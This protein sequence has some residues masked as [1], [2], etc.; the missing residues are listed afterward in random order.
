MRHAIDPARIVIARV[1][2][3][4]K[5]PAPAPAPTPAPTPAIAP[6]GIT[7]SRDLRL[8]FCS[9]AVTSA[10]TTLLSIGLFFYTANVFG[11]NA[12]H[13]FLLAA[14]QGIAY[15]TGALCAN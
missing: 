2:L 13:N 12:R 11:W 9:E 6:P 4:T 10:G 15:T 3:E 7:R 8:V 1:L 14:A 5:N